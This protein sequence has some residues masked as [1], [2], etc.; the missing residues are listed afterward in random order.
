MLEAYETS[1]E[2]R[3]GHSL[4]TAEFGGHHSLSR[5]SIVREGSQLNCR[6]IQQHSCSPGLDRINQ[7][8]VD[9]VVLG[10]DMMLIMC[11]AMIRCDDIM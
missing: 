9:Y 4:L 11:H 8:L 7:V 6:H 3:V 2:F 1:S 10:C 5:I